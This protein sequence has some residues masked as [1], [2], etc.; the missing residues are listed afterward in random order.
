[1]VKLTKSEEEIMLIVWKM[2][3]GF[4]KEI[5][6]SCPDPKPHYNT[7]STL[8]KFLQDKGFVGYEAFGKT[9][10]YFPLI[11]KES[12]SRETVNPV[13]KNYFNG[14]VS[15]LVSFFVKEKNISLAELET[16]VAECR[17]ASKSNKN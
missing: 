1:M 17:N 7:V 3:G 9:Y 11:S 15:Q 2:G 4:V 16:L 12:Y 5:L 8:I 10:R 14:S 6:K 13:L